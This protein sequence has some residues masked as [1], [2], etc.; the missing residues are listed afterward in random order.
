[1]LPRGI[2]V[3]VFG[4]GQPRRTVEVEFGVFRSQT[5]VTPEG[6]W[7]LTLPP[8]VAGGPYTMKIRSAGQT[9][10]LNDVLVGDVWLCSGQSNMEWPVSRCREV[11][12][13]K[14]K[15]DSQVR[16]F[17]VVR[18]SSE[19][20]VREVRGT[21]YVGNPSNVLNW[22]AIGSAFAVELRAKTKVPIGL[23]QAT[24]GGTKIE[25]WTSSKALERNPLLA[26]MMEEYYAK[27]RDY[28]TRLDT[29]Q[30][31]VNAWDEKNEK[32]D[33]GNTG[34][35]KGWARRDFSDVAWT[36]TSLPVPWEQDETREVD[37][38]VWYRHSFELPSEWKGKGLRLELGYIGSDDSTYVN[39]LKVGTTYGKNKLRS[40]YLGPGVMRSG[41]NT[42]AI[43]VWNRSGE[44]G[45]LGPVLKLQP[46]DGGAYLDLA[47]TW[48]TKNEVVIDP[49]NEEELKRPVRPMGPGDR[50]APSGAFNGMIQ[51]IIPYGIK[52]ILWYQG[53]ANVGEANLYKSLF[54]TMIDDW[55][56]RW[57]QPSLPFFFVQL[58]GY[59]RSASP[60]RANWAEMREAQEAGLKLSGVDIVIS[61][62]VGDPETIHP[63]RKQAIGK[64]LAALAFARVYKQNVYAFA[65]YMSNVKY[66][67]ASA[68]VIFQNLYGSL[69]TSDG[70]PVRGLEVCDSEGQWHVAQAE[71]QSPTLRV[72]ADGVTQIRG[73]RYCWADNPDGN[74]VNFVNTPVAPFRTSQVKT[75]P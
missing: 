5:M 58:P 39:G 6:T 21:W 22:S 68:R 74:L 15:I 14:A 27:L 59:G 17:K 51:P 43:R 28:R 47:T 71:L 36:D 75:S 10:V 73:V 2:P 37:G 16:L 29:W 70:K 45:M 53:E 23:I 9:V 67:G 61:T 34:Y 72:F 30:Q 55:R 20:P 49:P 63:I 54:P 19:V 18:Q 42:I 64:R 31:A 7:K 1:V 38:A 25:A 56:T 50:N 65:P 8:R 40:Y 11:D 57:G 48:K 41:T 4:L 33:P 13:I 62:D 26:P 52:G 69:K 35:E 3:P 46:T 32:R 44:G 12:D 24:W 66:D 60:E